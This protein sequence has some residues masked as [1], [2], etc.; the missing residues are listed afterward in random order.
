MKTYIGNSR[1]SNRLQLIYSLFFP[2]KAILTILLP[3]LILLQMLIYALHQEEMHTIGSQLLARTQTLIFQSSK[4]FTTIQSRADEPCSPNDVVQMLA[5]IRKNSLIAD[6]GRIDNGHIQCTAMLGSLV[7]KPVLI[8][9]AKYSSAD[10]SFVPARTILDPFFIDNDLIYN[11]N[12]VVFITSHPFEDIRLNKHYVA[13]IETKDR[14]YTFN[15]FGQEQQSW[16]HQLPLIQ[17]LSSYPQCIHHNNLCVTV[18]DQMPLV[19]SSFN[20]NEF[21]IVFCLL[22]LVFIAVK[23]MTL[24]SREARVMELRL[25]KAITHKQLMVEYQPK[26]DIQTERINGVETLCRWY[27]PLLGHVSPVVFIPLAEKNNQIKALTECVI[28]KALV[29]MA[30]ILVRNNQFVLSINLAIGEYLNGAFFAWIATRAKALRILPEQLMFEITEHSRSDFKQAENVSR[31]LKAYGFKVSIDDF[32]TGYSNLSWLSD[33]SADEV[34]I[35]RMFTTAIGTDTVAG[36]T[37]EMMLDLLKKFDSLSV[38]LEGIET[39]EEVCLFK[40]LERSYV[41]QGWFY[42]KSMSLAQLTTYIESMAIDRSSHT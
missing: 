32:G 18:I 24:E 13:Y 1:H 5:L 2:A 41:A 9:P 8:P 28:D 7:D 4:T 35:D 20:W 22:I 19:F 15:Q 25:R 31:L 27:D 21:V 36:K 16:I 14:E 33:L 26:I 40:A 34:K 23:K 11:D 37:L 38:V 42:A 12:I 29:D 3:L 39:E 10:H 17:S 30:D 6:I